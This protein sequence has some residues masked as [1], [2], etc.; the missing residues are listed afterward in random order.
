MAEVHIFPTWLG[1]SCDKTGCD[2]EWLLDRPVGWSEMTVHL[3]TAKQAGWACYAGRTQ[4]HYCPLHRPG[5]PA[6]GARHPMRR[7]WG[8]PAGW[9]VQDA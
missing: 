9:E 4:R 7:I 5:K 2:A 8:S 6:K 3:D 1:I